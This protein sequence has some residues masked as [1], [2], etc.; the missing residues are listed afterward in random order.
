MGAGVTGVDVVWFRRD[1]RLA[2]NP[3]WSG[4]TAGRE[5][6]PLF[7][8]D[9]GIFDRVSPRRRASLVAA[10]GALD[11]ALVRMGGRLRVEHGDPERVVAAVTRQVGADRVHV[12]G[13]VTPYGVDR[14]RRVGLRVELVSH[15]G[16]YLHP[17]GSIRSTA[18]R[19]YQVFT[20][21]WRVWEGLPPI[22]VAAMGDGKP[23]DHPGAGIPVDVAPPVPMGEAA[24]LAR[25]D[26]FLERVDGYD[27]ERDRIDLDPTSRLSIDLKYGTLAPHTVHRLVGYG[28]PGRRAFLRQLAWRDFHAHQMAAMPEAVTVPMRP[29]FAAM[30]W[31]DDAEGVSAW[32]SGRTGYPLVD[33]GMR[34]LAA[35][36]WIHNRVRMVVASFLV[37]DLLVD[38]RIG[39]RFLRRHL[40]DGDVAQNVGN[41]QWVAGTGT[42]AAPYTRVFNP[43]MQAARFDPDGEYVKRWVPEL[44]GLAPPALHAP[45]SATPLE[46]AAG[47]V[48]LGET[49]P[50]PIVAHAAA[51][52]RAL[53]RYDEVR[54]SH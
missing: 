30:R 33:A 25:L 8:V 6:C 14:D 20:P 37:K 16:L 15:P 7:V 44:D 36:G 1:L 24:A 32:K 29:E 27:V 19:P 38:W 9:P 22:P 3:A 18:G 39:E 52:Q 54:R 50:W 34:Q 28:T 51:R 13:D 45:W 10:L 46:L 17:P 12:N 41:W 48:I 40:L 11:D 42:D 2:D 47:G 5:V 35:E 53:D 43:V 21:F 23:T 26:S 4:G 31:E 49:Y